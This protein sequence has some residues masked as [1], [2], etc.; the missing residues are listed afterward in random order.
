MKKLLSVIF[1]A[2][3]ALCVSAQ[4]YL[5][6]IIDG[7][8][9]DPSVVHVGDDFYLINSSF[10]CFPGIPISQSKDL[11]HW[12]QIG[13]ALTR[14]SQLNLKGLPSDLGV[15]APTIRYHKGTYYIINTNVGGATPEKEGGSPVRNFFVTAKDP[16]GPWSEPIWLQQE[17][18]D[19]SLL[20]DD[21]K[22]YMVSN[23][24]GGIYLCEI[25]PKTDK[26]LT[27]SQLLWKGIGGRFPEGPHLY[28]K[29]GYYYLLIS[30]G[31]T[32]F[33]HCLTIARSKN[34]Y[35]P[36]E[37]NPANPIFTNCRAVGQN[38]LIQATGHGDFVQAKDGSWWVVFLGYRNFSQYGTYHHLGRET[39]LAP[40]TWNKGEWPVIN[41]GNPTDTVMTAK[42][43]P[44]VPVKETKNVY[45]FTNGSVKIDADGNF[46]MEFVRMQ[47]II[48]LLMPRNFFC[49]SLPMLRSTTS[50]CYR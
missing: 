11:I 23:P 3:L 5:N 6:P 14:T 2:C 30:E 1:A 31:G 50:L 18:I 45:D 38:S 33:A 9:P 29:D 24:D 32:E 22:C 12:E 25:D 21:G 36:Y 35:G 13:N 41:N 47:N 49:A 26:Q 44:Q 20:F 8:H 27:P 40:V 16:R 19:P 43:L 17:G 42:L 39:F 10:C 4:Q 46:P 37:S 34:P 7:Y 15:F 48:P 28:K